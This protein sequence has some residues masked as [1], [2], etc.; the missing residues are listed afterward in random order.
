MSRSVSLSCLF[1]HPHTPPFLHVGT[2]AFPFFLSLFD[3]VKQA[4]EA[5]IVG[6]ERLKAEGIP[7]R[8][9]T[10]YYAEMIKSDQHMA[11]VLKRLGEEKLR[12]E[13]SEAAKR[14][15]ELRKFGKSVQKTKEKQRE[16]ARKRTVDAVRDWRKKHASG[17]EFPVE[18]AQGDDV[19]PAPKAARK[20]AGDHNKRA[21][22]SHGRRGAFE[23]SITSDMVQ[24]YKRK[25]QKGREG[26]RSK[27]SYKRRK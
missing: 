10:D 13:A 1:P 12:V 21:P 18:L 23:Q 15:R 5:A 7:Y 25:P 8:R 3:S 11:K 2:H 9:P 26:K 27:V 14:Q 16:E 24:D 22:K 4:L 20:G 17:D 19:Q 6:C